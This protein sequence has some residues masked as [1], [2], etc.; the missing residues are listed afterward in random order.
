M[1]NGLF[2]QKRTLLENFMYFTFVALEYI[3]IEFKKVL[4][5]PSLMPKPHRENTVF[6]GLDDKDKSTSSPINVLYQSGV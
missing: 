3:L 6:L 1:Q 4:T 5:P 2:A